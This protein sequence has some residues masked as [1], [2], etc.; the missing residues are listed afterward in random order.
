[1]AG[2]PGVCGSPTR[3]YLTCDRGTAHPG[4]HHSLEC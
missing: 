3:L 1:M 4:N 2:Y